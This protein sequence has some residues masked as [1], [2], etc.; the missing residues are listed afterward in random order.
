MVHP[1]V[2]L[3]CHILFS[4]DDDTATFEEFMAMVRIAEEDGIE[5]LSLHL[6]KMTIYKVNRGHSMPLIS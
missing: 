5:V 2:D 6:M 4:F 3:N 1:V